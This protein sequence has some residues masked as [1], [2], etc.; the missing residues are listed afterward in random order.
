MDRER[1]GREKTDPMSVK[2]SERALTGIL[3]ATAGTCELAGLWGRAASA[4]RSSTIVLSSKISRS[5][6]KSLLSREPLWYDRFRL[7]RAFSLEEGLEGVEVPD[8][9]NSMAC[10]R[11]DIIELEED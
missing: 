10:R 8:T 6:S 7:M 5:M 1:S 4:L 9:P 11:S 2:V 3:G